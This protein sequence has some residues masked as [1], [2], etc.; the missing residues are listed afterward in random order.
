MFEIPPGLYSHRFSGSAMDR[1][2]SPN[3]L[4]GLGYMRVTTTADGISVSGG[5]DSAFL[6]LKGSNAAVHHARFTLAG[7]AT[8]RAGE[9]SWTARIIF[10]QIEGESRQVLQGDF[11]LVCGGDDSRFWLIST[12][13]ILLSGGGAAAP[14]AVSGEL[15]RLP[16]E[17]AARLDIG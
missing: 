8:R 12:G 1:N 13:S 3:Q 10:T 14:E 6:P 4:V 16:D 17:L 15:V 9:P 11:A 5:Q 2:T 7:N